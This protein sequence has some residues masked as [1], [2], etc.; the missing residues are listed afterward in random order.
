MRGKLGMERAPVQCQ[1]KQPPRVGPPLELRQ[2]LDPATLPKFSLACSRDGIHV[3]V[4]EAHDFLLLGSRQ[5]SRS[6]LL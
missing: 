5:A 3:G 2:L 6:G 4:G 1:C